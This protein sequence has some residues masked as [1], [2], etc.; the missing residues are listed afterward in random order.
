MTERGSPEDLKTAIFLLRSLKG[1]SRARLAGALG[2]SVSTISR[3]ETGE[4]VPSERVWDQIVVVLGVP[5][6]WAGRALAQINH[7]RAVMEGRSPE[8]DPERLPDEIALRV[9]TRVYDIVRSAVA[10]LLGETRDLTAGGWLEDDQD[11]GELQE[12]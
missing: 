4:I 6:F 8:D 10:K 3:Y 5:P 1:W 9:A 12:A 11:P 7:L 2:M